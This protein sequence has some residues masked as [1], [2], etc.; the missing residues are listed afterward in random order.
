MT[1]QL[2][3]LKRLR[4]ATIPFLLSILLVA[5]YDRTGS[6]AVDQQMELNE[7]AGPEVLLKPTVYDGDVVTTYN[8]AVRLLADNQEIRCGGIAVGENWVL[9]AAHCVPLVS[10]AFA[11]GTIS[12]I[13]IVDSF[14][15]PEYH[16]REIGDTNVRRDLALLQMENKITD[17]PWDLSKVADPDRT[18]L[19]IIGWGRRGAQANPSPD[20]IKSKAMALQDTVENGT[21]KC[22][23]FWN[24]KQRIESEEFCAGS[25]SSACKGDSGSP[26]FNG[27]ADLEPKAL[28]G[29]LSQAD[30]PCDASGIFDIYSKIDTQWI[31]KII[32]QDATERRRS[33]TCS[34]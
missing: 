21:L 12:S 32:A 19:F 28:A 17:S 26:L 24:G 31:K 11:Q 6:G 4:S 5:C 18:N 27:G 1:V 33:K 8:Y 2:S 20:L 25:A 7:K 14:C 15:H 9:T 29:I 13:N 23:T 16:S 30:E 10:K 3:Q 34:N 22:E